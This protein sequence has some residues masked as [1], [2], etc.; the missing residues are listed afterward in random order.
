M[1]QDKPAAQKPGKGGQSPITKCRVHYP[2]KNV[3]ATVHRDA[4]GEPKAVFVRDL[5]LGI[6]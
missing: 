2:G 6:F 5:F 3:E 1:A 4:N